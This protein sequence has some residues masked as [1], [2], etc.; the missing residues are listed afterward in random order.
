MSHNSEV[1]DPF[2]TGP[3]GSGPG[4]PRQFFFDMFPGGTLSADQLVAKE[5]ELAAS[6]IR[7]IRN[8]AGEADMIQ[9]PDQ[10]FIVVIAG[11]DTTG[12]RVW[13]LAALHTGPDGGRT[14]VP[15]TPLSQI[16]AGG[17]RGG[18][19]VLGGEGSAFASPPAR[20][21]G[22]GASLESNRRRG[23]GR[24]EVPPSRLDRVP[25]TAGGGASVVSNER[26]AAGAGGGA[27][28]PLAGLPTGEGLFEAAQLAASRQRRKAQT[29]G[30]QGTILAGFTAG[31]PTTRRATLI[32]G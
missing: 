16:A 27:F 19:T 2:T 24:T 29:G 25:R 7:V 11:A 1:H 12:P 22:G 4:S 21:A 28:N 5:R 10:S 30:R 3:R 18:N 6:G 23:T 20:T 17:G 14:P 26:R 13:D 31:R 9:L 15:T 8:S 32:G